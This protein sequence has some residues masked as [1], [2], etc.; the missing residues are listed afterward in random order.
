MTKELSALLDGELE[1]HEVPT[2]WRTMKAD[3]S[4]RDTWRDYQLIRDVL[5][6][7]GKLAEDITPGVMGR[8]RDEPVVLAPSPRRQSDWHGSLLALAAS[9]T[10][11]AVVGWLALAQQPSSREQSAMA[12]AVVQPPPAALAATRAMPEY[13]EYLL[14]HQANAPGLHLQGGAQHIRTVSAMG[15]GQ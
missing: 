2:M 3:A 7:E 4:L 15:G 13:R 12:R 14:A 10:G 6:R 9:V 5:R 11:I 1:T 8:L